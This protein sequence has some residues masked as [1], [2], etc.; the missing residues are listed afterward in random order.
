MRFRIV[1]SYGR[2]G[3]TVTPY[4]RPTLKIGDKG[5]DVADLQEMLNAAIGTSLAMDG[6]FGPATGH[7]V[8]QF[9]TQQHL[10]PDGIVGMTTWTALGQPAS[11]KEQVP[12]VGTTT[13]K[14]GTVTMAPG[15]GMLGQVTGF[16]SDPVN[17]AALAIGGG[18]IA[19]FAFR[20]K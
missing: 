2:Y 13:P 15:A 10:P 7:A 19:Y 6:V 17:L 9:Q 16:L 5:P 8:I 4:G 3:A 14:P 12:V 11:G 1:Q 20:G 18:L